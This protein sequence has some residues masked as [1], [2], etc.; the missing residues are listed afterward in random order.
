MKKL[1]LPFYLTGGT[2]L[3]RAYF[4]HRYSDDIDLFVNND[5]EFNKYVEKFYQALISHQ[6][7]GDFEIDYQKIIK[8]EFNCQ[9]FI[10]KNEFTLKIDLV[11][12][13]APYYGETIIHPVLLRV[14]N[15]RNILSN[16]FTALLRYEVK[17]IVDIWIICKNYKFNYKEIISEA[18]TKEAGLDPIILYEIISSFP[19]SKLNLIKWTKKPDYEKI[20][21]DIKKIAEDLLIGRDNSLIN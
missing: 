18:K 16:K 13:I 17:D 9:F 8:T 7:I 20:R 15:L 3:S 1:N 2:A 10:K 11:N 4:N 21:E 6:K 12:D 14:D 19:I 5:S